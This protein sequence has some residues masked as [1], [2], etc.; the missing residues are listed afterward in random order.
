M[1]QTQSEGVVRWVDELA[2][3]FGVPPGSLAPLLAGVRQVVNRVDREGTVIEQ[4]ALVR[5]DDL[6]E[7]RLHAASGGVETVFLA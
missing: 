4:V 3:G 2:K 5:R 6:L 1:L 7:V